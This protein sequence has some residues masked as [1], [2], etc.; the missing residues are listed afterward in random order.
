VIDGD[1]TT[2]ETSVT[3]DS[4]GD[5]TFAR[6][7]AEVWDEEIEAVYARRFLDLLLPALVLPER[8]Q[9]L[10]AGCT[11]GSVIP[12]IFER[13]SGAGSA[14]VI[15]LEAR[16]P[17][18]AKARARVA[19]LDRK[20]VFLKG[21][22]LGKLRFADGVFASVVSNL[23]WL[24]LPEPGLALA[25]FARVLSPAGQLALTVPLDGSF[26]EVHDLFAEVALKYD[27]T[28]VHRSIELDMRRHHPSEAEARHLLEEVGLR[29]VIVRSDEQSL[30]FSSGRAFFESVLVKALFEPRWR[31]VVGEKADDLFRYTRE[32][33]DTYFVG[34]S[35]SVRLV[36]GCVTG[37]KAR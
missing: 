6:W 25:E 23:A 14:R 33:I 2:R 36:V 32:A 20:R 11:T 18:L 35:L 15:A 4:Q 17:L 13:L 10:V 26:Q 21:E 8:G 12:A 22:S 28:E 31:K 27:M 34:E 30:V 9:I 16:G 19:E 3:A 1:E 24:E 37:E 7:L 5:D 29:E